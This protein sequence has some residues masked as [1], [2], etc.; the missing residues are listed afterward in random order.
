[1]NEAALVR[2][3]QKGDR[4]A[5]GELVERHE[6]A[7]LALARAYFAS[8][9]DAEDATQTA[10]LQAFKFLGKLRD[11]RKFPYWLARITKRTCLDMLRS[12]S[13]VVSLAG[14]SSTVQFRRRVGQGDLT[15][16]SMSSKNEEA[17][18]VK[19]AMGCLSEHHRIVLMLRY[20]EHMS[21]SQI[22]AYLGVPHTTVRSRLHKGKRAL[23]RA[24]ESISS[25]GGPAS[26]EGR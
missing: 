20:T 26:R 25:L 7:M 21:Y 6:R 19:A 9:S 1:M 15:P 12:R 8:E 22:A 24:L 14:F 3:A 11:V 13:D 17:E 4:G 10:F 23:R 18:L 2:R 5:F 16:A